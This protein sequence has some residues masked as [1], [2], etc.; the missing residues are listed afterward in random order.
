MSQMQTVPNPTDRYLLTQV[1]SYICSL[2]MGER[3]KGKKRVKDKAISFSLYPFP[4][5]PSTL[6]ILTSNLRSYKMW[7]FYRF[8]H[9][10]ATK[11]RLNP[12]PERTKVA[13]FRRFGVMTS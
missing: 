1:A 13:I 9:F 3:L 6:K 10:I 2:V 4:F 7:S 11:G 5:S 12:A 8:L